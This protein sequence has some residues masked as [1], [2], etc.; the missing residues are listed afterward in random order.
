MT[1]PWGR[2]GGKLGGKLAAAL[3]LA[4]A[5]APCR[6]VELRIS[7]DALERTLKQQL[8]SGP[9]GRY[10]IV[11]VKLWIQFCAVS[12]LNSSLMTSWKRC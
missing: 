9:N 12:A 11:L 4:G 3:L 10:Y 7:R 5:L 8:F 2:L 1:T 6:A